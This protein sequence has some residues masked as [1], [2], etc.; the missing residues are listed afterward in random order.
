MKSPLALLNMLFNTYNQHSPFLSPNYTC[1]EALHGEQTVLCAHCLRR[2]S[3]QSI[4]AQRLTQELSHTF[5]RITL[6]SWW[7][8]MYPAAGGTSADPMIPF[9][10]HSR[11]WSIP[12]QSRVSSS[13]LG[14]FSVSEVEPKSLGSQCRIQ[15]RFAA[16]WTY[17]G[18]GP[19]QVSEDVW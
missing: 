8:L 7:G 15:I 14:P 18:L 2:D 6:P 10:S 5:S 4:P 9:R 12:T 3:G 19:T 11:P 1:R 17:L 13:S 16:L